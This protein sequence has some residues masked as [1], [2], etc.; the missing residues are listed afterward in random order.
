MKEKSK[1]IQMTYYLRKGS[2][3]TFLY[4]KMTR[5]IMMYLFDEF[6]PRIRFFIVGSCNREVFCGHGP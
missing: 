5:V 6:I 3:G 1:K 2:K 4:G